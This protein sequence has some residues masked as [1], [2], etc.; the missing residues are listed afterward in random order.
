MSCVGR[1]AFSK[2]PLPDVKYIKGYTSFPKKHALKLE[3][4]VG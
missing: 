1:Y 2:L 3:D 4:L